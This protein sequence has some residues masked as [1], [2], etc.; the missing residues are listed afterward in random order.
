MAYTLLRNPDL[1][2]LTWNSLNEA[3]LKNTALANEKAN[4][5][6]ENNVSS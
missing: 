5:K 4:E 1:Q 3:K 6:T 2:H